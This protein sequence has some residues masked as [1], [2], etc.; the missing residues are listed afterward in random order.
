MLDASGEE[1]SVGTRV[2]SEAIGDS[3]G[4]TLGSGEKVVQCSALAE[5]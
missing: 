3:T 4:E 1:E 5:R 2:S